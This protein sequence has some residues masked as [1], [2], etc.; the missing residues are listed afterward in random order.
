MEVTVSALLKRGLAVALAA[1]LAMSAFGAPAAYAAD[2]ASAD[3]PVGDVT[4]GAGGSP[5]TDAGDDAGAGSDANAGDAPSADTD[6]AKPA[7]K[8]A[9]KVSGLNR[10]I[11]KKPSGTIK[12][13]IKVSP[14]GKRTVQL[15]LY[16]SSAKKWKTRVTFTTNNAGKVTLKYP[17]DWKK[18]NTT[19]WRVVVKATD[20]AKKCVSKTVQVTTC[21]RS[22]VKLKA[23]SAIIMEA[24]TGQVFY[25]KAPD[26]KRQNASTTKIMTALVALERNRNKLSEP[27]TLTRQAVSTEYSHLGTKAIG[28]TARVKDLLYMMLVPSD[29]GAAVALAIHTAGSEKAFVRMMNARAKQLGCTKTTFKTAHGLTRSG[30]GTTARELAM[31]TRAAMRNRTFAKIV[32]TRS[33]TFT[34]LKKKRRYDCDTTNKLLGKVKGVVG[35]KT[36]FTKAAGQCFVGVLKHKGKTYITVVLGSPTSDQRWSDAKALIGYVKKYF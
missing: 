22:T 11:S 36:G 19:K 26:V 34:T 21:N 33:Y 20:T 30:H 28:D 16:S 1:S 3:V 35:G 27:V 31:I 13:T 25:A 12:D 6:A 15:Q 8:V 14:A 9:T 23:K 29:N 4:A 18:S 32:K 7:P 2:A 10:T 17:T 24:G 5:S